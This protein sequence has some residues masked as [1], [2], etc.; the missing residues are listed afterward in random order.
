MTKVGVFDSGVGGLRVAQSIARSL[1]AIEV[2]YENDKKHV[3][4]GTKTT[5]EIFGWVVPIL[6]SLE[7]RGCEII[8]I[9]CNTVTTTLI[10]RLREEIS[11]PLIGMEPVVREAAERSISNKIVVC[12]T[13][14]TLTSERYGY[15]KSRLSPDIVIFE[16][17]CSDW[18]HMI[19]QN[20]INQEHIRSRLEPAL[21]AGADVIVLGC[22]HYHWI[23]DMIGEIANGRAVILQ[24]EADTIRL[25]Q[26]E[27][28]RLS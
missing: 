13:P 26:K 27:I 16:P 9:A 23:E 10:E 15:V 2:I 1:P 25:L 7:S 3:P 4:Y 17:N 22:T 12:A 24:S 19:E 28:E 11:V 18:A 21:E 8:V 14:A 6:R 20:E 5:D